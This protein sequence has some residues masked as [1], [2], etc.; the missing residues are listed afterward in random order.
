MMAA[1]SLNVISEITFK[2]TFL[3]F[4]TVNEMRNYTQVMLTAVT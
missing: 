2:Q 4:I 3:K 1:I